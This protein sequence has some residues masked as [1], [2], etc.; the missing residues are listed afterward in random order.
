MLRSSL[1]RQLHCH[2]AII[3][4]HA[5]HAEQS[6]LCPLKA[7]TGA[8]IYVIVADVTTTSLAVSS[9]WLNRRDDR[10]NASY[11]TRPAATSGL[12][13][14]NRKE[15]A[16]RDEVNKPSKVSRTCRR[17]FAITW[18]SSAWIL[19]QPGYRVVTAIMAKMPS[20]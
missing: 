9:F 13:A 1:V 2:A 3:A 18:H 7:D 10:Y 19:Q 4:K 17:R 20:L 15:N 14:L 11:E 6:G 5:T 12:P 16:S 8:S